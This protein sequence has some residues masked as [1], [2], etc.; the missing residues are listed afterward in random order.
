[1][2]PTAG[3]LV[4]TPLP[5][6]PLPPSLFLNRRL[7]FPILALLALLAVGL[8]ALLPGGPLRAQEATI[9]YA[10]NGTDPVATY[11]AVDPEGAE[12]VWE[13][14]G[15]DA[16]DFNIEGGVLSFKSAPDYE[17]PADADT[18][19]VYLVTVQASD[20]GDSPATKEVTVRVTNIDE[21][22][23]VTLSTL[24][25]KA[26][27]DLTAALT[28]PDGASGA[29]PPITDTAITSDVTWQ[30]PVPRTGR[31]GPTLRMSR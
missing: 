18:S 25:P 28:D 10:E 30:W 26:G 3:S 19:N 14:R 9:D 24:Q 1:M 23:T 2:V 16:G 6:A 21:A 29:T 27:V 31:L 8:L 20:G 17:T 13:L 7:A 22:G 11:T 4:F 12:I 15:D 5:A